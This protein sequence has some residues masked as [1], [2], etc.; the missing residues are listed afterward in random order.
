M[1]CYKINF[2]EEKKTVPRFFKFIFIFLG[3]FE[4]SS[5]R[6]CRYSRSVPVIC[7]RNGG[8]IIA[9]FFFCGCLVNLEL[10]FVFLFG[11][12]VYVLA[13]MK[14]IKNPDLRTF[15]LKKLEYVFSVLCFVVIKAHIG[16][17]EGNII[18]VY[19]VRKS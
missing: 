17:R 1:Y 3:I 13:K 4:V 2:N 15:F 14:F 8:C 7:T 6:Y 16:L 10:V 19:I 9:L 18:K 12:H 11:E 5:C